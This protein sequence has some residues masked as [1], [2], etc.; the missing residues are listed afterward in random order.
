MR[1]TCDLLSLNS[2]PFLPLLRLGRKERKLNALNQKRSEIGMIL[3]FA[4]SV[5][6]KTEKGRMKNLLW[7][8]AEAADGELAKM[9]KMTKKDK[10]EIADTL[11]R[12]GTE[13]G[14]EN[15]PKALSTH[16]S[17][18]ADNLDAAQYRYDPRI[19]VYLNQIIEHLEQAGRVSV[20]SCWAG[21]LAGE[22]WRD[23]V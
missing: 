12:F 6:A 22:R 13:S 2:R 4:L 20:A 5:H 9:P 10:A 14:W 17:F 19:L 1:K 8:L 7:K 15:K 3:Q 18:F 23:A 21:G 16:L 11:L